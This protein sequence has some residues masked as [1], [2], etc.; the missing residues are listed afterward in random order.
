MFELSK[1]VISEGNNDLLFLSLLHEEATN[2]LR[3][4][5][6][7]NEEE[8]TRETKRLTQH[9]VDERLDYLYKAEGGRSK[10]CEILSDIAIQCAGLGFSLYVLV[11]LDG[12]PIQELYDEINRC[13]FS[14][15]RNEV[16]LIESSRDTTSDLNKL[17]CE[18]R[19]VSGR[20]LPIIMF[21][22]HTDLEDTVGIIE[23]DTEEIKIRKIR[24]YISNSE[25]TISSITD[26]LY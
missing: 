4:D 7:H 26:E 13:L 2:G 19:S 20:Q 24:R 17:T 5:I 18:I 9:D 10:V 22:F 6:F 16:E 12:D 15:Y 25:G 3:Y 23:G 1:V 8:E 11:D 21:A 14:D